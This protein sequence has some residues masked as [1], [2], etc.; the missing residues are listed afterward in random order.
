MSPNSASPNAISPSAVPPAAWIP[1]KSPRILVVRLSAV[2]D[3]IHSVPI[4]CALRE[5][6]PRARIDWVAEQ[7]AATL[8]ERHAALDEV[9]ALPRRWLKSPA[10]VW[11]LRRRLR[12]ARYDVVVDAH[13]LTKSAIV[14]LL[15]G[16][17]RRIGFA[18][19][20]GRELSR[21][22]YN[23]RVCTTG[24]HVIDHNLQ[25][26]RP[27]GIERPTVRFDLP[28]RPEAARWAETTIVQAGVQQG[29]ALINPG[30]GWPSKLWPADRY[31]EVAA[32]LGRQWNLPSLVAWAG[33]DE[34]ALAAAI[35]SGS[36]DFAK[37]APPTTLPQLAALARR[38]RLFVGADTGPLHLAVAVDTPCVGLYGPWPAETNG[39]YGQRH[40]AIQKLRF[41]GPTHKRRTAPPK[42]MEAID[43]ASVRAACDGI[44][45]REGRSAA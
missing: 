6:F 11:R 5:H 43:V 41:D 38:A 44:L 2:G 34:R 3:V 23:E 17:P 20:R 22:S 45:R 4:A 7:K 1:A 26:L 27:L 32:H 24:P 19:W 35:A 9:I 30:A 40:V 18:G 8:L 15:S 36:D 42:Y 25:L 33:D 21:L 37:V 28:E 29:F 10:A 12:A 13:G 16:A 31:A 14:A 39:P